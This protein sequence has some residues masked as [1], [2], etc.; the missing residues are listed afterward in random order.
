MNISIGYIHIY[1]KESQCVIDWK[2]GANVREGE[3]GREKF[4]KF[5]KRTRGT[6]RRKE[7][8]Y[9]GFKI[10]KVQQCSVYTFFVLLLKG[11]KRKEI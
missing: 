2:N 4:G 7:R 8:K 11:K 1:G 3:G 9:L 5:E 6:E 10:M